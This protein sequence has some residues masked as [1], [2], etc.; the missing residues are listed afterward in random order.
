M[1]KTLMICGASVRAA[2]VSAARAGFR[3]VACDLFSDLDLREVSQCR[4]IQSAEYPQSLPDIADQLPPADNWLYT[5]GLENHPRIV[6]A[7]S[8]RIPLVGTGATALRSLRDPFR[9]GHV[10]ALDG[11]DFPESRR[12]PD[13]LPSDGSW[14]RKPLRSCGGIGMAAWHG[15]GDGKARPAAVYFQRRVAGL[16]CSA[17]FV[18]A[19]T[20]VR[21]LGATR[22]ILASLPAPGY[23]RRFRY[24]GS[25]GPLTIEPWLN[26]WLRRLGTILAGQ[27]GLV[28]LFGVDF[29]LDR[30]SERACVVEV[31]PRYTASM[32]IIERTCGLNMIQQHMAACRRDTASGNCTPTAPDDLWWKRVLYAKAD[33]RVTSAL[34]ERAL[35]QRDESSGLPLCADIPN[36]G[37]EIR[38]GH[39][40]MTVFARGRSAAE[41]CQ[42][43]RQIVNSVDPRGFG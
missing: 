5:G 26:D 3:V 16:S 40:V 11:V 37:T 32:E 34:I 4:R 36:A 29:L 7:I 15:D 43:I 9:L 30:V 12:C 31:N 38:A 20:G 1:A 13:Q 25:A 42:S 22:Q 18:A 10:L 14:I 8:Q 23:R 28:G 41:L 17:A 2:A 27:F 19:T 39:P 6:A 21:L 35:G 33:F 24:V